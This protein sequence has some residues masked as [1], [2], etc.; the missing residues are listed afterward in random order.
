MKKIP[1]IDDVY[2]NLTSKNR[3]L[4]SAT[5]SNLRWK[6]LEDMNDRSV[7]GNIVLV[8]AFFVMIIEASFSN[9]YP[10]LFYGL[11]TLIALSVTARISIT[12]LIRHSQQSPTTLEGLFYLAVF[13][14]AITWGVLA[15][16]ILHIFGLGWE[17]FIILLFVA[18][19]GAG[20]LANFS[21]WRN[22]VI[23]YIG[24]T[25]APSIMVSLSIGGTDSYILAAGMLLY[26]S[27]LI[28]QV[29]FWND[30][31]WSSR[32]NE[33]LL[34]IRALELQHERE[35][36]E[37]ANRAKS[38]FLSSMSHELRTPLN[39][40]LGFGQLLEF[41]SNPPLTEEQKDSVNH[42][43]QGGHHLLDL[44]NDVLDLSK[45]E[46]GRIDLSMEPLII[47]DIMPSCVS[48]AESMAAKYDVS[49]V[50]K[51]NYDDLA[52][53]K[54][55]YT[56]VKQVILN[57]LSN[58]VKYN[59][60]GGIVTV[61]STLTSDAMLRLNITDTGRGI[62]EDKR[63]H[64]FLPFDRLGAE[65]SNI[66][67][68]GIGLS[69][70]KQL[71]ELMGGSINFEPAKGGGSTFWLE[72]STV[73]DNGSEH[74]KRLE[75]QHERLESRNEFESQTVLYIEDNPANLRLIESVLSN[76]EN[77]NLISTHT[78]ELGLVMAE[79]ER[80]DLIL[81]DIN[82][83]G[84]SGIEAIKILQDQV[85]TKDIPVI[86]ISAAAMKHDIESALEAGVTA[87]LTKPINVRECL[88]MIEDALHRSEPEK[89]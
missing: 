20:A 57:L 11:L 61:T 73:Q 23:P 19:M 14:V 26:A 66:E 41:S 67:G 62:P 58:A 31:Y 79:N 42:I 35:Q 4:D 1:Q 25:F 47:K 72:F 30:E 80:P 43:L 88:N 24:L 48:M 64:L 22:L 83:P 16:A 12:F 81:M 45:I 13:S 82:L 54:G 63:N 34:K 76:V 68:T 89:T 17:T 71:M 51:I 38:K 3:T 55:D 59:R 52:R 53:F 87:Y 9:T 21:I 50:D 60:P 10:I 69:I 56:R 29:R 27:F 77:L 37:M 15:A 86:A 28:V 75:P 5:I 65:A 18:G 33:E 39:A 2:R 46:S 49:V 40:I 44:I 85:L 32:I 74:K 78:A 70:T 7:A 84:M 6:A 36:S 8:I